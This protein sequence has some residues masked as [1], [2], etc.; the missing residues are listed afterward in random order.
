M[1]IAHIVLVGGMGS[2]KTTIAAELSERLGW[3]FLDSDRQIETMHGATGRDLA[4]RYGVVWLH[5]AEAAALR[6]ALDQ[7][8]PT[9]VA[10]A[11]SIADDPD[12]LARL[13]EDA[14]VALL[15]VPTSLL[16]ERASRQGH[17]RPL[18]WE[19]MSDQMRQ[20]T[21]RLIE[22]ADVVV[23]VASHGPIETA[24]AILAAFAEAP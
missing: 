16:A 3:P 15:N 22:V 12:S 11:A 20:R 7:L 8:E 18:D 1:A 6:D 19:E 10:A 17:R 13:G 9:V 4:E 23:D 5:V 2:G 24:D 21:Q 14:F